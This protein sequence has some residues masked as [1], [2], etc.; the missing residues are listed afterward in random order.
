MAE[1]HPFVESKQQDLRFRLDAECQNIL[2]QFTALVT[3]NTSWLEDYIDQ[4][5]EQQHK[6]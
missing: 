2:N 5:S 4:A 6:G 3:Q 1:V